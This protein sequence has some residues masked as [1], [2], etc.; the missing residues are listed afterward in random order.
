V[1]PD[2]TPVII[3]W[4]YAS[5]LPTYWEFSTAM[6]RNGS[7]NDDWHDYLAMVLDEYHTQSLWLST[8]RIEMGH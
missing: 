6:Y 1:Q 4:E 2:G 3:D 8:M 7:F 5:W